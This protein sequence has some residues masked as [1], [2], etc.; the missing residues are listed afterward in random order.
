M[1]GGFSH[2]P[3]EIPRFVAAMESGYEF[4]AGSRFI[5]GGSHTGS[6]FRFFVSRGGTMLTNLLLGTRMRDMTS[7]FECFS[8]RAI[9]HVVDQGVRSRAHFFQTEI[10]YMLHDWAWVEVPITYTN[11]S[12]SVG[13]SSIKEALRILWTLFRSSKVRSSKVRS[14]KVTSR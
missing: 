3:G 8:R 2:Q 1:D 11:P 10:R 6:A 9:Q 13:A 12:K 7:G 14:S 4:A 5:H